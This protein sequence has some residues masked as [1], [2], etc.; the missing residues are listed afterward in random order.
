[1]KTLTPRCLFA[2][3]ARAMTQTTA[4]SVARRVAKAAYFQELEACRILR[5]P[6]VVCFDRAAAVMDETYN[7]ALDPMPAEVLTRCKVIRT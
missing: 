1:M 4:V 5:H 7:L 3:V 2:G 6:P